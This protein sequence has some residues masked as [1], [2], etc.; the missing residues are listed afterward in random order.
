M[1]NTLTVDGFD[2]PSI[3]KPNPKSNEKSIMCCDCAHGRKRVNFKLLK[4]LLYQ[5]WYSILPKYLFLII[6]AI[7]KKSHHLCAEI[8]SRIQY[9]Q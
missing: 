4:C 3:G 5:W 1:V 7:P 9:H 8:S 2:G 6:I